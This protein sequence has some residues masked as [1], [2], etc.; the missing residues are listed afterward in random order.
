M[1]HL[2]LLISAAGLA[3]SPLAAS[4]HSDEDHSG[5]AA[6]IETSETKHVGE[7]GD[8]EKAR[9]YF[10]DTVL[11]D[12]N[13]KDV[14]FYS[15]V[16]QGKTVVV[17]FIFTSCT[18]ACPLIN[19]NLQKVQARLGERMGEDI[20]FVS[21]SVD[22]ETD[23]PEKL[24]VYRQ[25]F[26]AG[27]GW[28][29]LTGDTAAVETVSSKLGQVFEKEAHLT[30]LLIGNTGTA[31]WRKLPAYLPD[32]VIAGQIIDIADDNIG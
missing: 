31:R 29:F 22:P 23:T 11:K 14:R 27:E 26:D 2:A 16:L 9:A 10:T 3:L 1:K 18:D 12:H 21:I 28:L 17:S 25:D 20:A 32:N 24:N 30:A 4:A 7:V 8:H 6:K 15:D 5:H 19:Q 13:G